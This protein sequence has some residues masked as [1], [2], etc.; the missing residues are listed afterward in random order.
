MK[1][2]TAAAVLLSLAAGVSG[3]AASACRRPPLPP[4]P[5]QEPPP[6]LPP[7]LP[8]PPPPPPPP[9]PPPDVVDIGCDEGETT[10]PD[11]FLS[12]LWQCGDRVNVVAVGGSGRLPP[13][14]QPARE[15]AR[16]LRARTP[17]N[18]LYL[19]VS[20]GGAGITASGQLRYELREIL[21]KSGGKVTF[22]L[23]PGEGDP[24]VGESALDTALNARNAYAPRTVLVTPGEAA[25][26]DGGALRER[27]IEAPSE[28][29][30]ATVTARCRGLFG[31]E[32]GAV[33]ARHCQ[34]E[35]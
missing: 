5:P 15:F 34:L 17:A 22:I 24:L 2:A 20:E 12:M 9:L 31:P 4:P 14:G 23:L 33:G 32:E 8:P 29:I 1:S 3:F 7:P 16:R 25:A 11:L 27:I 6:P 35:P 21:S 30:F 10:A 26:A 28:D 18:V 19:G 13:D